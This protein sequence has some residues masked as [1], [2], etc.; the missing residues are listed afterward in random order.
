MEVKVRVSRGALTEIV[1]R[2]NILIQC[3]NP[4]RVIDVLNMLAE[5]FGKT[6]RDYVFDLRTGEVKKYLILALNGVNV[7]SM[8]GVETQIEDGSELLVFSATGGG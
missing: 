6:F 3:E 1:G 5:K 7:S 8:K 4:V 2:N